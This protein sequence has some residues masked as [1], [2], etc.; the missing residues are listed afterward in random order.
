MLTHATSPFLEGYR[1]V[2]YRLHH[3]F[4][5]QGS[6]EARLYD[7]NQSRSPLLRLPYELRLQIYELLLGDRQIHIRFVPWQYK[8]RVKRGN[9][10]KET[11]KGHFRYEVLPKRQDPWASGVNQ[12]WENAATSL[13]AAGARL[14][15]LS[16]VC[17]QLYDETA[18]LPQKLNIWSFESMHMMERYI[19]KDNRMHLHQRKAIEVL[20][21]REKLPKDVHKKLKWLKAIVWKDGEKLRWQDLELF[22]DIMWKDRQ[23]L[24]EQS[25]RW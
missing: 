2:R 25:W 10:D 1:L 14:T 18:L 20:Y 24:L 4:P 3:D 13:Q 16:G 21:C 15:L 17:R 11:V 12:L 7:L 8:R 9:T 19:L 23:Q 5:E 22:P 6:Q